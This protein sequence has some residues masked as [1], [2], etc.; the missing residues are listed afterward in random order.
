MVEGKEIVSLLLN[1]DN[2]NSE[3]FTK[4]CHKN[5]AQT[6]KKA[7]CRIIV[8]QLVPILMIKKHSDELLLSSAILLFELATKETDVTDR[9]IRRNRLGNLSRHQ[10]TMLHYT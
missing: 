3:L 2:H 4:S 10:I 6:K 8:R 5:F 9:Q 1:G 7:A